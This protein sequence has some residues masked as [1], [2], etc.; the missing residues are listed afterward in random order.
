MA[1]TE[2]VWAKLYSEMGKTHQPPT[3]LIL[4]DGLQSACGMAS[5]STGPF[6]GPG[7]RE[8]YIDLSFYRQLQERFHAPGDFGCEF[9]F[10]HAA[11]HEIY[12]LSLHDALPI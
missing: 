3:L 5:S 6:Y 9:F 1:D 10:T 11:T 7:D 8:V 2:D 12:T 4:R